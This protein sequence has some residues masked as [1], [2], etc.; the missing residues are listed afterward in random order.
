MQ[1]FLAKVT[2]SKIL[3]D[4]EADAENVAVRNRRIHIHFNGELIPGVYPNDPKRIENMIIVLL[5]QFGKPGKP[6]FG[7]NHKWCF[8]TFATHEEAAAAMKAFKTEEVL[9]ALLSTLKVVLGDDHRSI[10]LVEW[11]FTKRFGGKR[12]HVDV[13]WASPKPVGGGCDEFNF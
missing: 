13:T 10:C 7:K 6:Y 3:A 1:D 8:V 5:S 11:L 9:T 12:Y 4:E 2:A